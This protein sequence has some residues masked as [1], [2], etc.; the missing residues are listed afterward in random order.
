MRASRAILSRPPEGPIK[1]NNLSMG[2]I[3]AWGMSVKR[4]CG[5]TEDHTITSPG[6]IR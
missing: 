5:Q 3:W 4:P 2:L 6:M 1:N